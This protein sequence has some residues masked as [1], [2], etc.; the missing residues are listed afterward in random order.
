M[1]PVEQVPQFRAL[2]LRI[3]LPEVV[4]VGE[5]PLLGASLFLVSS[6]APERGVEL[7]GLDGIEQR[8]GLQPVAARVNTLFLDDPA[9]VDGVLHVRHDQAG[10]DHFHEAVPEL[11]GLRKIVPGVDVEQHEGD[12]RGVERLLGQ[13]RHD[14][15]VFSA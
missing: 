11:D 8:H 15:G 5:E 6:T 1:A 12:T 10:A 13:I 7:V 4:T 2:P 9:P 14:D 3:P